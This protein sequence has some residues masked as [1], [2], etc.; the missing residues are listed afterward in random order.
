VHAGDTVLIVSYA[1]Y[2]E[3]EARSHAPVVLYV[4]AGNRIRPAATR[5]A[6]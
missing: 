2:E 1:E 5:A 4:D 6:G 3:A